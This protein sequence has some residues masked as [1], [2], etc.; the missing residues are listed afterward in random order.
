MS[1]MIDLIRSSRR[2]AAPAV[3]I[4]VALLLTIASASALA[5]EPVNHPFSLSGSFEGKETPAG[6]FEDAC[7]LAIDSH[8]DI[9]VSDYY[10]R[11]VDVFGS[12][13]LTQL[14]LPPANG[15]CGLAVDSGGRLYVNSYHEGVTRFTPSSFPPSASTTYGSA[16]VIDSAHSTG[17]ALDPTS[18]DLYV[19]DRTYIAAYEPS[20]AP[21]LSGGQPLQIGADSLGSGYGLAVSAFS[22]TAG[23][24]YVADATS[25]E[26]QIYNSTGS[27]IGTI[28]GAGTPQDGFHSLL[29]SSLAVDQSDGHL[30]VADNTQPGFEHPAAVIDEFNASGDYRSQLPHP[31]VDAEPLGLAVQPGGAGIY[32]GSGNG[33]AAWVYAFGAAAAGHLLTVTESG[34]GT[35][36]VRSE[37]A[38][39]NCP[40]AC[41]AEFDQ[42][43]SVALTAGPAAGSSFSGWSGCPLANGSR[44]TL[45]MG[46]DHTVGAA[47]E[48][49]PASL[50][51]RPGASLPSAAPTAAGFALPATLSLHQR[52]VASS[53]AFV[54]V[55]L[56]SAGM[57]SL[58]GRGLRRLSRQTKSGAV[59]LHLRL[60]RSGVRVLARSKAGEL[61]VEL[62]ASFRPGGGGAVLRAARQI[63]FK[64]DWK[65]R[66]R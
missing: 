51:I 23:D 25:A 52:G 64:Q 35:G 57:L 13:Y 17:L 40:G 63:F 46:A 56:P 34:A 21:V 12:S 1:P 16:T 33:E 32:A 55:E 24:L 10:H 38:G 37:P 31:L 19:D 43:A 8:G 61:E 26:V 62:H 22:A 53:S 41:T 59:T 6:A 48:P 47:F 15:P 49:T 18:G 50:S 44:C 39:I 11:V 3:L 28:D 36:T 58:R 60:D 42:A 2:R 29:D 27:L 9:Y 66:Q 54:Q 30:F 5:A 4:F 65:R 14:K 20:G 7:G 45:T